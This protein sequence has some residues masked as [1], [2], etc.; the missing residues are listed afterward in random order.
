MPRIGTSPAP[1][2]ASTSTYDP[3]HAPEPV[4]PAASDHSESGEKIVRVAFARLKALEM[5]EA[6]LKKLKELIALKEE[7][8]ALSDER[9]GYSL[10]STPSSFDDSL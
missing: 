1:V 9:R 10:R 7:L 5:K 2:D 3:A 6:E 8:Q 4:A